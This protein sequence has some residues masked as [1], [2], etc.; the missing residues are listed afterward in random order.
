MP[1]PSSFFPRPKRQ[2]PNPPP[3]ESDDSLTALLKRACLQQCSVTDMQ[4]I[5]VIMF[6]VKKT[7]A[8]QQ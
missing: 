2:K 1:R 5:I 3:P 6:M 4:A 8:A 7:N